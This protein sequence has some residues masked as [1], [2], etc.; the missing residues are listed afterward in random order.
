MASDDVWKDRFAF[1]SLI[2]GYIKGLG[3]RF[4]DETRRKLKAAGLDVAKMP[5]AIPARQMIPYM[6]IV[7][8]TA[9]PE[10]P[11][12]EQ[13]RLLGLCAIRGWQ[14]GLLGSAASAMIRLIGPQRALTRLDR[15][16]STTNNYSRA[17]TEF[18]GPKEALITV[19]D[20]QEMPTYW[21]GIFQAGVE[22]LHL[23]GTVVIDHQMSPEATFRVTWK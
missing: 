9:W 23:E 13:L 17:R 15:A 21:Q 6:E 4:S 11:R 20:V 3:E 7:A 12:T 5:P 19:N 8:S 2:E 22:L 16:F 18:L 1:P 10:Q 14:S